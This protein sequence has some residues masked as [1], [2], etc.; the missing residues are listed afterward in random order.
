M[1]RTAPDYYF[2]KNSYDTLM[3]KTL[4]QFMTQ[5]KTDTNWAN[6]IMAKTTAEYIAALKDSDLNVLGVT[7]VP[8]DVLLGYDDP[9]TS[10]SGGVYT[11][12]KTIMVPDHI[13]Y[14]NLRIS[15]RIYKGY[16]PGTVYGKIYKNGVAIGTEFST[17]SSDPSVVPE[18]IAG[19]EA[20][21]LI[22]MWG[23]QVGGTTM[24]MNNFRIYGDQTIVYNGS[25]VTWEETS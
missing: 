14:A 1:V 19:W 8:S 16:N 9:E 24:Y 17:T 11:W 10:T 23:K 6:I 2:V 5:Y 21:D 15:F 3:V 25:T 4:A 22:E 7:V 12:L 18:D 13:I 20:G